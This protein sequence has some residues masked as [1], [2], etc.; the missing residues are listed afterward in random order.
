MRERVISLL[1]L[2]LF[3]SVSWGQQSP[4]QSMPGMDMTGHDMSSI[5]DMPMVRT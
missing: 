1:S 4:P 3:A 5:K 2:L